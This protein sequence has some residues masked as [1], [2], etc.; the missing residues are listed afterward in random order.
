M[1]TAEVFQLRDD[2]RLNKFIEPIRIFATEQAMLELLKF[3]I[4]V[5]IIIELS[6]EF[7]AVEYIPFLGVRNNY[8]LNFFIIFDNAL[9]QVIRNRFLHSLCV[10]IIDRDHIFFF[11]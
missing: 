10:R 1:R 9:P 4:N 2:V 8:M 11:A 3:S 7:S 6:L 5:F